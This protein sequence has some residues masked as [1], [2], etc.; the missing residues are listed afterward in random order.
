MKPRKGN[1]M[2]Q[3][4]LE[5]GTMIGAGVVALC[6]LGGAFTGRAQAEAEAPEA[7]PGLAAA[8]P[9]DRGIAADPAVIYASGFEDGIEAPLAPHRKGV[10]V[11]E[12]AEL[13]HTGAAAARIVATRG[14]D[15][16]GDLA[17][18]WDEGEEQVFVRV[19]IRFDEQTVM[20]H[21][22]INVGGHTPT[23]AYRWGGAAG[24]RPPGDEDGAF[25]ATL[26]P[27]KGPNDAWK[28]Y[29]YWHEMRSWQTPEGEP[30]G[31]PNA[32]YGNNF[33]S[34]RQTPPLER[35]TWVCV[36]YMIK[37][38]TI[39]ERDGEMAFWIDG[40]K[41]GH[42][43]PGSPVGRWLRQN[44]FTQGQYFENYENPQPFEGFSWRTHPSLK[45]NKA[46]LQWYVSSRSYE[47]AEVDE[48][49]VYFDNLV[50]ANRYIG[51]I[52]DADETP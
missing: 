19:Y 20:P 9:A 6:L 10:S 51:P 31:R 29:S 38:N 8:Y 37:L 26:E 48:N 17:I 32:Y 12:D 41:Y 42:W 33:R 22:F 49:I 40:V 34:P 28:F 52:A 18:Q 30:D 43:R 45:V 46:S 5:P 50:I 4:S 39:G 16:G 25:K 24:L 1:E 47:N 11:V 15:Q 44:F 7:G 14:Q 2:M 13:A 23:Y 27:P 35:D 3:L 36:E 21:H